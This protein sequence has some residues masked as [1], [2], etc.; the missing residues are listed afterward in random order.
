M[1]KAHTDGQTNRKKNVVDMEDLL[2]EFLPMAYDKLAGKIAYQMSLSPDTVKYSYLLMFMAEKIIWMDKHGIVYL[3]E[4]DPE[5]EHKPE[6]PDGLKPN[7]HLEPDP[8]SLA[9]YAKKHP[10]KPEQPENKESK[11]SP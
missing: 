1:T 11:E 5:P 2:H 9:E 4:K 10:R 6:L 7:P 3:S 8:E